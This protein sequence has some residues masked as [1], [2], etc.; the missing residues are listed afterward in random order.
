[1]GI[2]ILRG[3]EFTAADLK[4]GAGAVIL[5]E[6][7][8]RRLFGATDPIGHSLQIAD[9]RKRII[10][11]AR[12]SKYWLLSEGDRSALYEPYSGDGT[13]LH[14]LIR[15]AMPPENIVKEVTLALD[16]LDPSAAVET[17]PMRNALGLALLPSEAG[18]ALLGA[19]GFLGLALASMGLYGV[20]VYSVSRRTREIGLRVAIGATRWDILRLVFRESFSLFVLGAGIGLGITVLATR[21]LAMFLVAGLSPADPL[22]YLAVVAVLS[23]VA[24]IATLAPARRALRVDPITALHYE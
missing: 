1:M 9:E 21:P 4:A 14:F 22:T 6:S 13:N 3:R 17:K 19:T 18:A 8:A 12:N 24:L 15:S 23:L 11:V 16:R 2:A 10:G 7:F 20:L 5:N